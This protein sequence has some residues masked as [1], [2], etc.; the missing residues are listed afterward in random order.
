MWKNWKVFEDS[1]KENSFKPN[2]LRYF[3]FEFVKMP[4]THH[5]L[6]SI[7]ASLEIVLKVIH[8]ELIHEFKFK[9]ENHFKN[10]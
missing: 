4:I 7:E 9:L 3:L 1:L 6:H 10:N 2:K 8:H 5:I